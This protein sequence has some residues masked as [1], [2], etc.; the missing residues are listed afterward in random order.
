MRSAARARKRVSAAA[1]SLADPERMNSLS[2]PAVAIDLAINI[3]KEGSAADP[4]PH[5][6][7]TEAGPT[8]NAAS[9][10]SN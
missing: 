2:C 3:R 9:N 1:T 10:N 5:R 6:S 8:H 7:P 4:A